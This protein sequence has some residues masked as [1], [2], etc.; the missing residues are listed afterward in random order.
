MRNAITKKKRRS[1]RRVELQHGRA[2]SE[3]KESGSVTF[4]ETRGVRDASTNFLFSDFEETFEDYVQTGHQAAASYAS[5]VEA[6][7]QFLSECG[8][9]T[10][11]E[12]TEEVERAKR[13][14]RTYKEKNRIGRYNFKRWAFEIG[15]RHGFLSPAG[16]A[17][18][19]ISASDN[20]HR[21]AKGNRQLQRAIYQF[22]EAWHWIHFE[23][24][25]EH[26]LAAIGD[27]SLEGRAKGPE[28]KK[29]RAE[30]KRALVKELYEA[31]ASDESKGMARKDAKRA[32]GILLDQVNK[33]LDD[34]N[35]PTMAEKSLRDELRPL[36]K[37]R[38]PRLR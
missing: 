13:A 10:F 8:E 17:A 35:I 3:H 19:F 16:V 23:A 34:L 29:Q 9:K 6:A 14:V 31:F 33:K 20:V 26:G 38:F 37:E 21:L 2:Q 1:L 27:K 24:K 11:S 22:A 7:N 36:V 5:L 28:A 25:G 30:L 12:V 15:M 32:A 4:Y 18:E